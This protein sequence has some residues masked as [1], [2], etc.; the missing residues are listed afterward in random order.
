MTELKFVIPNRKEN[1]PVM[2][3]ALREG[4]PVTAVCRVIPLIDQYGYVKGHILKG[5]IGEV[6]KKKKDEQE[7]PKE[8]LDSF[9]EEDEQI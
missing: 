7:Q 3:A 4:H 1:V 8:T 9:V 2:S 6:G 5:V